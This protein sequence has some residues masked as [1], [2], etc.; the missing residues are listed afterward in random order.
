MADLYEPRAMDPAMLEPVQV[1]CVVAF[2]LGDRMVE[3]GET[4]SV[5]R[6]R[7]SYLV[8]LKIAEYL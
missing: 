6:H 5:P 1:R 2:G 7:A 3:V 8:F 4:V